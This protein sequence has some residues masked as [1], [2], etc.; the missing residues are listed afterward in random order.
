MI[1]SFVALLAESVDWNMLTPTT[2]TIKSRSLSSRR[3]W[4]EIRVLSHIIKPTIKSLSSRR[5]W[6]EIAVK[7]KCDSIA[8]SL[9]SRRAWIEI[10]RPG[11]RRNLSY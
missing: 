7:K 8:L 10:R 3:A 2:I 1:M 6:I 9:S 4:I 5:A 11:G